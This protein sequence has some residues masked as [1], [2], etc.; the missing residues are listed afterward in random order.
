VR[1]EDTDEATRPAPEWRSSVLVYRPPKPLDNVREVGEDVA[2]GT[3]VCKKGLVLSPAH[4][5]L[6]ASVGHASVP[7]H[8]RPIV[9][10]LSTGTELL[11]QDEV[12]T[13]GAIRDSNS[14]VLGALAKKWGAEIRMLGIARDTI[15]DLRQKLYAA[16]GADLIVTSGGVS[17]GDYDFVKDVLKTEGEISVWQVRMKPGKPLA[18]GHIGGTPLI[19]LPGNPV[20]AAVSFILFGRPAILKMLGHSDLKPRTVAVIADDA[21]DNRGQ[22]RHYVR[23]RLSSRTDGTLM[24]KIAGAQGAGVLSSLAAATALLIVPEHL[25]HVKRGTPLQAIPLD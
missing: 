22:R 10:V 7:V 12:L 4:L 6:L 11:G 25:E 9:A 3:V 1:F 24:A 13:P 23:V 15:G 20:A 2:A 18:F 21:I 16:R 14:F 8:R 17:L 5:G 19:G